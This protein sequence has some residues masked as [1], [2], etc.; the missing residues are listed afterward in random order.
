MDTL[1]QIRNLTVQF[2]TDEGLLTAVDQLDLD[3][4]KGEVLGLVGESGSGKSVTAQ[5][6][7]RLVPSPPGHIASGSIHFEDVD[8]LA[9]PIRDLRTYRGSRIGIIF[10]EPMTALSPLHRVGQQL[11]ETLRLHHDISKAEAVQTSIE[12]LDRVGIPDA[13]Q[14]MRNYPYQLSGG[15]RQRVMIAMVLMLKPELIIADEPTTA[16]DVTIQAQIFDLIRE[17]KADSTSV[18]LITHDMGV[19]WEMCNRVAVMYASEIVEAAPV[20]PLFRSPRHPYTKALLNSIPSI[21]KPDQRLET[22]PGNVPSA[23]DYPEGCH[24]RDRCAQAKQ[25]CAAE[26]PPLYEDESAASRCFLSDPQ[27]PLGDNANE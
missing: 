21:E 8:L 25:R 15:M 26:H 20:E 27:H 13:S 18:L 23:L 24:F 6:I 16:L 2:Q 14:R 1:L 22:I 3:I 12:W 17:M 11:V 10:Q 9:L 4:H 5:S 19:I 7:L